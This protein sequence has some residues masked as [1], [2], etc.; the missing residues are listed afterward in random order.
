MA[1]ATA[2]LLATILAE[3][4]LQELAAG[5]LA[6]AAFMRYLQQDALYLLAYARA[7]SLLAAKAPTEGAYS[8]LTGFGQGALQVERA[9][10]QD[11]FAR[12]SI[13]PTATKSRACLAYT[14]YLLAQCAL[15]PFGVGMA[16]V[17]PCFR[18]YQD[19]GLAT[20]RAAAPANP[21]AAWIATYADPTFATLT[22]QAE[23]L[24]DAAATAASPPELAAMQAA[25]TQAAELEHWFWQSAY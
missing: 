6:P 24:A 22:T 13:A 9:L 15:A 10:H 12:Y 18:L 21:Y 16:V 8:L 7:Q 23:A 17:L 4:F 5:T 3:P 19:V 20:Y 2:P 14:S 11:F 25:Y 1:A